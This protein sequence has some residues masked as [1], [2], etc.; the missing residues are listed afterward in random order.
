MQLGQA[1]GVVQVG[2]GGRLP[3]KAGAPAQHRAAPAPLVL[4]RLW[5][6]DLDAQTFTWSRLHEGK[7]LELGVVVGEARVRAEPFDAVELD[8]AE[9]WTS[10]RASG[11]G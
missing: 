11:A 10:G 2:H 3:A 8:V 9:W 7:W 5:Y 4:T 1:G 6:V